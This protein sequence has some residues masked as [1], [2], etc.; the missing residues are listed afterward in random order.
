[1]E[2]G[3][4]LLKIKKEEKASRKKKNSRFGIVMII[5]ALAL[6]TVLLLYPLIQGIF[7]AFTN[8]R[9]NRPGQRDFVFLDNFVKLITSDSK[10]YESFGFT[11][12]Y[13]IGVVVISYIIGFAIAMLLNQKVPGRGIFR[14]LI[15]LPWVISSSVTAT[16]WKWLLNERYGIVNVILQQL[17]IID[18][19]I[20]FLAKPELA[21]LTVIMIGAWKSLPFMTIVILAGLQS[22]STE[23]YEAASIDGAGFWK[24]LRYVTLPSIRGITTMCTT[25]QFIWTFNNFENI[26]LMT[27]G[28]PNDSTYTLPIYIYQTAFARSNISYA[29]AI[30][31]AILILMIIFT[32]VRFRL[33]KRKEVS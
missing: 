15:L 10:F 2:R 1:M 23:L 12:M 8:Y 4:C 22:V 9:F 17:H 19:P 26:Y 3:A 14:A 32:V 20:L 13:S 28:G 7:Y 16:N 31:V 18:K 11:L 24:S 6:M 5:P 25:L 27:E 33:Q 29:A 21:K 30:A